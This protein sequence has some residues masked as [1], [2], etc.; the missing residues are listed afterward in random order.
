MEINKAKHGYAVAS[1][2]LGIVSVVLC[3]CTWVGIICGIVGLVLAVV[4]KKAGNT[5]S[6]C[7][8]GLILSIIGIVLSVVLL[9]FSLAFAGSPAYQQLLQKIQNAQ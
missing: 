2:V 8:A 1:L 3:C 7:K 9:I 5:E 6:I 4:A